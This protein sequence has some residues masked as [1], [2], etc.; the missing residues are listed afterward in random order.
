MFRKKSIYVI[1]IG[2][3]ISGI[4]LILFLWF[5]SPYEEIVKFGNHQLVEPSSYVLEKFKIYDVV[6]LG[7]RH[8]Q[9]RVLDFISGMLPG[10]CEAGVSYLGLEISS[11]QQEYIDSYM[12][13]GIDMDKINLH[14]S[15]DCPEYRD[16]LKLIRKFQQKK[17]LK[18]VALDLPI[19]LYESHWNRDE[20]MA[21]SISRL[22]NKEPDAKIL[23]IVGNLHALKDIVWDENVPNKSGVIR[24]YLFE[25]NP[26]LKV[27]SICQCI[28]YVT[29]ENIL[30]GDFTKDLISVALDCTGRFSN[31]KLNVLEAV[32]AKPMKTYEI[33]DGLVI[34]WKGRGNTNGV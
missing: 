34:Y 7:T 31:C 8:R 4:F 16:L 26:D 21:K 23:V 29:N 13:N 6:L 27:F 19:S 25:L 22:L 3:V 32:A 5:D 11:D 24:S 15:I 20:W 18:A 1:K 33:T 30:S 10:L 2:S 14:H 9:K 12:K 17:L 28:D